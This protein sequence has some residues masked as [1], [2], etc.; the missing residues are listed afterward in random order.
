MQPDWT[1]SVSSA[2]PSNPASAMNAS[3]DPPT[4]A[5]S[6]LPPGPSTRPEKTGTARTSASTLAGAA[7]DRVAVIGMSGDSFFFQPVQR[8]TGSDYVRT[9]RQLPSCQR[10]SV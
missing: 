7:D 2:F 9:G 10:A 4:A 1:G 8:R 3:S 6:A 5:S